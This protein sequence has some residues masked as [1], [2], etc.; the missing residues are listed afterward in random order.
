VVAHI[1][2]ELDYQEE[3]VVEV[4]VMMIPQW[5]VGVM[6][7][8]GYVTEEG[9]LVVMGHQVKVMLVEKVR[10][11][12]LREELVEELAKWVLMEVVQEQKEGMVVCTQYL[13]HQCIM[14][15]VV[16][17]VEIVEWVMVEQEEEEMDHPGRQML[18]G[19]MELLILGEEEEVRLV[20]IKMEG[21]VALV[22]L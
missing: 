20:P 7:I 14:E 6:V 11:E 8:L 21:M 19:Q 16:V 10:L 9:V 22:L 15:E 17:V 1:G 5:N 12:A 3:V 4:L 13:V 18:Q 2:E